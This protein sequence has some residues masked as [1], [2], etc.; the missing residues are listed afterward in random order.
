LK[1]KKKRK[2]EVVGL[3]PY[4]AGESLLLPKG[5]EKKKEKE[6]EKRKKKSIIITYFKRQ[7]ISLLLP[8]SKGRER[9]GREG[10]EARLRQRCGV[11][12]HKLNLSFA[13]KRG[14]KGG[15]RGEGGSGRRN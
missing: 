9:K 3:A 2:D 6:G 10:K 5:R 8:G 7:H 12:A 15:R 11:S 13:K 1:E 4:A 14:G